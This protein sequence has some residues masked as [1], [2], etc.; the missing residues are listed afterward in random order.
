[1]DAIARYLSLSDVAASIGEPGSFLFLRV[2][3]TIFGMSAPVFAS[4]S[5]L[6]ASSC[7]LDMSVTFPTLFQPSTATTTI[8]LTNA[9]NDEL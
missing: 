4:S 7:P 8:S 3:L 5:T 9:D 1:L 6:G 2:I